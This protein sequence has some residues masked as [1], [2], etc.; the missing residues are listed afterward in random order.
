MHMH[1]NW[2]TGRHNLEAVLF[3]V[4]SYGASHRPAST[5]QMQF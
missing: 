4:A 3:N 1:L 5:E 2:P